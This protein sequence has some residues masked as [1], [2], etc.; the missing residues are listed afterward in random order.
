[1]QPRSP[2]FKSGEFGTGRSFRKLNWNEPSPTVAYGH[3]EIHV[4]PDG[5]R[6]LSIY[7]AML[8]QGFPKSFELVGTLSEQVTQVSNAVPPPVARAI[9]TT[10]KT[11]FRQEVLV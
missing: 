10:L 2:K 5:A 1:M 6:R 3:R 11:V 7:E 4:H 8:L 9:A